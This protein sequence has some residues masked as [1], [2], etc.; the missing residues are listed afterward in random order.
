MEG[1]KMDHKKMWPVWDWESPRNV[2]DIRYFLGFAN[3]YHHFVHNYSSIVEPLISLKHKGTTFTWKEEELKAFDT[4]EKMFISAPILASFDPD[5]DVIVEI[6]ASKYVSTRV[7]SQYDDYGILDPVTHCS[8]NSLAEYNYEIY[9]KELMAIIHA[10]E[11]WRLGL[12][13]VLNPI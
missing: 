4:L 7:L 12:Q 5:C 6:D 2:K 11:E 10:F 3:F 1:I 8:K 9:H 13:Y